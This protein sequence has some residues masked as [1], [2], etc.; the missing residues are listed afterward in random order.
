VHSPFG[1][2]FNRI[3]AVLFVVLLLALSVDRHI[4]LREEATLHNIKEHTCRSESKQSNMVPIDTCII[5]I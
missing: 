2:G 1:F 5:N 4:I 3:G